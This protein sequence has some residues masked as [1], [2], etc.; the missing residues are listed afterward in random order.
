MLRSDYIYCKGDTGLVHFLMVKPNV[1]P[2]NVENMTM[3]SHSNNYML[4]LDS[5]KSPRPNKTVDAV[6]LILERIIQSNEKYLKNA[7]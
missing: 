5:P 1:P 6:A 2:L 7:Q 4:P 3:P